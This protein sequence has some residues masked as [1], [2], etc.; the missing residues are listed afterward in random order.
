VD[1]V[2]DGALAVEEG[3]ANAACGEESSALKAG[4]PGAD[5]DDVCGHDKYFKSQSM[6]KRRGGVGVGGEG[7]G[8]DW[9]EAG[10]GSEE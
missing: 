5:D 6:C 8:G 7:G 2:G 10:A 3:Y 1:A 9:R 4:Q